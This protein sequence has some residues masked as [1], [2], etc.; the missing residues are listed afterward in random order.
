MML[1]A[2]ETSVKSNSLS[3]QYRTQLAPCIFHF[4]TWG[5]ENIPGNLPLWQ[6][7]ERVNNGDAVKKKDKPVKTHKCYKTQ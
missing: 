3:T 1:S 2:E 4:G 5:S 7:L 6:K